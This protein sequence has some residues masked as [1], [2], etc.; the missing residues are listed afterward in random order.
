MAKSTHH[1]NPDLH[2]LLRPVSGFKNDPT[3]AR[4]HDQRDI[5]AIAAS[6]ATHGQQKTIVALEDGTV[7]AGNGQLLAAKKLGWTHIAAVVFK[8]EKAA[9]A[10]ALADNRTAELSKWD[11]AELSKQLEAL[12]AD[13]RLEGTGFTLDEMM[14]YAARTA[15]EITNA[16]GAEQQAPPPPQAGGLPIGNTSHVRMVQLF[17]NDQ[18]HGAFMEKVKQLAVSFGVDNTT[19]VCLRAIED[20]HARSKA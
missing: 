18:N 14:A 8:D 13:G 6:Y 1:V 16:A 20:A 9:K 5:N 12:A 15:E 19:D 7:I 10:Y 3:N 2:S 11:E 4:A 17:L